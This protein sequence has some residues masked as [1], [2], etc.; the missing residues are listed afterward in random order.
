MVDTEIFIKLQQP[1]GL[2]EDELL[3]AGVGLCVEHLPLVGALL[4]PLGHGGGEGKGRTGRGRGLV[5]EIGH[6]Q[7]SAAVTP[8]RKKNV[9]VKKAEITF[10]T[11][12]VWRRI[13]VFCTNL[14]EKRSVSGY[15]PD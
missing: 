7:G 1:C 4:L 5:R 3:G 11:R 9:K 14:E 8:L 15:F 12:K 2:L 13:R 6:S 10:V